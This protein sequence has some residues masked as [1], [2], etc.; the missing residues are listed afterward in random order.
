[1]TTESN[2]LDEENGDKSERNKGRSTRRHVAFP[3]AG[4][5]SQHWE[6]TAALPQ[7]G[8][9]KDL[10]GS[11][12]EGLGSSC[13]TRP[14]WFHRRGG[15]AFPCAGKPCSEKLAAGVGI[16]EAGE[17]YHQVTMATVSLASPS[18][19]PASPHQLVCSR[20]DRD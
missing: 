8:L 18:P 4:S 9:T 20:G 15:T 19:N 1:M 16:R 11:S 3:T 6:A 7:L 13:Q 17:G 12:S 5:V 14:S 2:H 10:L